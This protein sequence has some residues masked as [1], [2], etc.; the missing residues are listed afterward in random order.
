MDQKTLWH[1]TMLRTQ[2]FFLS[3]FYPYIEK[4]KIDSKKNVDA[5]VV[6]ILR[7]YR[8]CYV[9]QAPFRP[10]R[11]LEPEVTIA[12]STYMENMTTLLQQQVIMSLVFSDCVR[13]KKQ[14]FISAVQCMGV[15]CCIYRS[16][17]F[18]HRRRFTFASS[19]AASANSE[20]I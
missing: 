15:D 4:T 8:N 2:T 3:K 14:R 19:A 17:C 5:K 9:F 16:V 1:C 20:S 6:L 12:P 13:A 18:T 10:P 11:P 7:T